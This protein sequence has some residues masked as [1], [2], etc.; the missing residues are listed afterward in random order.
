[1][2]DLMQKHQ[3]SPWQGQRNAAPVTEAGDHSSAF[4]HS[5]LWTRGSPRLHERWPNGS[6]GIATRPQ[7]SGLHRC[8]DQ[9]MPL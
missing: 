6:I 3:G 9:C 7:S 2:V 1:M 5:L 8:S 4:D